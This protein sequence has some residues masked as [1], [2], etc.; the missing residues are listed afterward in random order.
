MEKEAA[1]AFY[2]QQTG[3]VV[4]SSKDLTKDEASDI[5]AALESIESGQ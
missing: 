2:E 3:R 1:L 5:I 4:E